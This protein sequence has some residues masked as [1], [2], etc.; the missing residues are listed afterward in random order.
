MAQA[1]RRLAPLWS[2]FAAHGVEIVLNGHIHDYERWGPLNANGQPLADGVT[3]IVAGTGG[4]SFSTGT[5]QSPRVL[6]SSSGSGALKLQLYP[7]RAEFGFYSTADPS[8]PI[9][10]S[11]SAGPITCHGPPVDTTPPTAPSITSRFGV[12]RIAACMAAR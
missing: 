12:A 7:N 5:A 9:D 4:E 8:T 11:A 1:A 2:L 6:A 10:S 3:Q